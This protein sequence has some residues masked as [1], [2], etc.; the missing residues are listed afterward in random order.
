MNV[1][2]CSKNARL[3]FKNFVKSLPTAI[4]FGPRLSQFCGF[5]VYSALLG[6]TTCLILVLENDSYFYTDFEKNLV[7]IDQWGHE[8]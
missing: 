6:Q 4:I 2:L 3:I 7:E 5:F 8:I 1:L